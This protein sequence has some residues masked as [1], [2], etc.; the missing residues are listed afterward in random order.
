MVVCPDTSPRGCGVEGEDESWDFGSGASFYVDA[1]ED[2]WKINYRM[3]SY[4]TKELPKVIASNFKVTDKSSIMGHSMG[5]HGALVCGLR[6][7]GQYSS[8]SAFAPICHPSHC[9]WGVKAFTGYLGPDKATWAAYD[10]CD[11]VRS[12]SGPPLSILVDQGTDDKFYAEKQLLP[13][14]LLKASCDNS[15]V[16]VQLRMQDQYSHSYYF[17]ASFLDDHLEH[18]AKF[19]K[20]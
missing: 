1:T 7:P 16:S 20:A 12:Y 18:H 17:I 8:V 4:V 2:K 11:L 9:P 13:E 5:G 10:S 14:D 3:F 19:L 15:S 6:C